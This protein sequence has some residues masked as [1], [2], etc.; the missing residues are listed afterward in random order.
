MTMLNARERHGGTGLTA[1]PSLSRRASLTRSSVKSAERALEVLSFL[2]AAASPVPAAVISREVGLPKSSMYHLLNVMVDRGFVSHDSEEGTWG[3]GP[4]AR[5]IGSGVG[6]HEAMRRL[7][8]PLLT[9]L[10]ASTKAPA[11]LAVLYGTDA[12]VIA[13]I[14]PPESVDRGGTSL[15][16]RVPAHATALGRALLVGEREATLRTLF[17]SGELPVLT[18]R[19]PR[20]VSGLLDVLER[21]RALGYAVESG[22]LVPGVETIA[23]PV[24]DH[25]GFVTGSVG[26]VHRASSRERSTTAELAEAVRRSAAGLSVRLGHRRVESAS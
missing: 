16:E 11:L 12:L 19:G 10:A 2:S 4:A 22:E 17:P 24:F 14:D 9:R 6:K 5:H 20:G 15:G 23:A 3:L 25:L 13:R 26:I 7:S 18:A 21:S 1:A 8:R